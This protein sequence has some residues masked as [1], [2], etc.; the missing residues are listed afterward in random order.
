MIKTT[1]ALIDCNNFYVSCERLFQPHLERRP[2]VVLSNNDGCVVSRS[3]EAKDLGVKMAAP[4]FQLRALA[5]RHRIVARSSN[6]TLYAD[7]SNRVMRVLA[8]FSPHQE[9]YSIDECFLDFSQMPPDDLLEHGQRCRATVKQWLGLPVCVGIASTKTLAKLANHF[10]KKCTEYHGVCDLNR[11]SPADV[12]G[13]LATLPVGVV[14]GVGTRLTARL[15]KLDVHTVLD[16]KR[17][18]A[19]LI[20]A[21]GG[22]V[23]ERTVA[24]LNNVSCHAL[25]E[26]APPRKQILCSRSFGRPVTDVRELEQAVVTYMSRAAEKLR[27]QHSVAGVVHVFIR[28]NSFKRE[29]QYQRGLTLPL[30]DASDDTRVLV[31]AALTGVKHLYRPGF[32]YQKAGVMLSELSPAATRQ[33]ALFGDARAIERSQALMTTIDRI[34]RMMGAGTVHLL[35]EG[36]TAAWSMRR[37]AM[38][39]QYTTRVSDVATVHA[40]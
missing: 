9:I 4:W 8:Q 24:E 25:E 31:R 39:P 21:H 38:S 35:G 26:L 11:F 18:P 30:S 28:T 6:Y 12:D 5:R 16:L 1:F 3:Q 23:L 20:R 22:V 37:G 27:R 14:W 19:K 36:T 10:A 15:N 34:N 7:L 17:T 33:H 13:L 29:P 32:T 40:Q 2:V